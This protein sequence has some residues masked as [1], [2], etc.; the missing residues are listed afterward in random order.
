MAPSIPLAGPAAIPCHPRN[1]PRCLPISTGIGNKQEKRLPLFKA[2][3]WSCYVTADYVKFACLLSPSQ[4]EALGQTLEIQWDT[5]T[6][7]LTTGLSAVHCI[8]YKML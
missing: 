8:K 3:L 5:R 6:L 7:W 2:N 1:S 4:H